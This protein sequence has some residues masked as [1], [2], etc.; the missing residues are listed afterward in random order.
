MEGRR[1]G[2]HRPSTR[3]R[4]RLSAPEPTLTRGWLDSVGG[5]VAHDQDRAAHIPDMIKKLVLPAAVALACGA[6]W[7]LVV[8]VAST[9]HIAPYAAT[10][11]FPTIAL[12]VYYPQARRMKTYWAANWAVAAVAIPQFSY[13]AMAVGLAY[14]WIGLSSGRHLTWNRPEK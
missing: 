9:W 11:A 14:G 6:W 2:A 10:V 1:V 12:L 3:S 8:Y 5:L 7:A 13:L 4:R